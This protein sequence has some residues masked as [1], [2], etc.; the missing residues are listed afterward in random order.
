MMTNSAYGGIFLLTLMFWPVRSWQGYACRLAS[1]NEP[2]FG[3]P[4]SGEP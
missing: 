4:F 1:L 3:E 2:V